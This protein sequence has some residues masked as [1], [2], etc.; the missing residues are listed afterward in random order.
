MTI[1][2]LINWMVTACVAVLLMTAPAV[3]GEEAAQKSATAAAQ[4]ASPA[5][6]KSVAQ[7]SE[8]AQKGE[9]VVKS[10]WQ[11]LAENRAARM[12]ARNYRGHLPNNPAPF[13]GV[14]WGGWGCQTCVGSGVLL[15]DA[16]AQSAT[17]EV[18][19]VRFWS[20]GSGGVQRGVV[21]RGPRRFVARSRVRL[22]RRRG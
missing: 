11:V 13:E 1:N 2:R 20:G 19:R 14:G 8:A 16:Q 22:F 17:G 4:K 10:R 5:A 9:T 3:A 12:A 18:F 7:K 15:A 21:R 6:Q